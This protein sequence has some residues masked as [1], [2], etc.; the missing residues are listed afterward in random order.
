MTKTDCAL[1]KACVEDKESYAP[2]FTDCKLSIVHLLLR[3]K[4]MCVLIL[5][6]FLGKIQELTSQQ[7]NTANT[8]EVLCSVHISKHAI[9]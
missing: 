2:S 9:H 6:V 4:E 3:Y 5:S 8:P 1:C 7:N